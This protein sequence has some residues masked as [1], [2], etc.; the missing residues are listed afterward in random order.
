VSPARLS[1]AALAA[2]VV[3]SWVFLAAMPAHMAP[4]GWSARYFGAMLLMWAVMMAAMMLP[5]AAPM[6]LFHARIAGQRAPR[7]A[8]SANAGFVLGYLA[9]WA[10][11]SAAAT[12][13]QWA[14]AEA[15]LLSPMMQTASKALAAALLIA[16]GLY[17]WT[18]LKQSC[19]IKC[20]SPL[21]FIMAYWR[22]GRWGS[23]AMGARHGAFCL[24]CCWMLMLLLFV[25]GVM[26]FAWIAALTAFVLVEKLA[27]AG[28]W[29]GRAAGIALV[30]WGCV[31]LAYLSL[32][33]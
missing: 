15:A 12:L 2:L 1:A 10:L 21:D 13:M 22:G 28:H 23:F 25:G 29:A 19:L 32:N 20:R 6:V 26:S 27:P 30:G 24:G 7:H 8:L 9:V 11:F 31:E 4:A 33:R 18:P 14:L 16:A 17:Q 3:L 5:S